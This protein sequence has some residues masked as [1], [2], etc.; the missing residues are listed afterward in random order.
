MAAD[1]PF[2]QACENNKHPILAGIRPL[3]S[4]VSA[5]LEVGSGTGQHAVHFAA[6]LPQL[7]WHTSD[8][9]ANHAA[10]QAW[11]NHS[12][13]SNV[14]AP[15]ELDVRTFDWSTQHCE[16]IY[17]ANAVHI[18]SWGAAQRFIKSAALALAQGGFFI[19]YG[20]FNYAGQYT[21]LSNQ[22]FDRYLA[23]Q[24]PA[25]GI[26]DF[27]AINA[28]AEQRQLRLLSDAA[29]PANN[30]LLVWQKT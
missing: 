14:I 22:R 26:R 19:L 8:R 7:S 13:L 9:L 21:S 30:R 15:I 5:V 2:S 17:A 28:L 6:A 18:M 12:D 23:A 24:H 29:M 3:L 1:L 16:A 4:T 10:I 20:P 25:S 27:T 11:I